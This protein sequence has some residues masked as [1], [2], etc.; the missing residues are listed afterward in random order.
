MQMFF[1]PRLYYG[2][3]RNKAVRG[4]IIIVPYLSIGRRQIQGA[5]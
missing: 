3:C 5:V 1:V 2:G 4:G